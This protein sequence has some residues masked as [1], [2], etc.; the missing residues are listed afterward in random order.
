[1]EIFLDLEGWQD[2]GR[3]KGGRGMRGVLLRIQDSAWHVGDAQWI[4]VVQHE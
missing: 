4:L 1:M 2:S 3:V